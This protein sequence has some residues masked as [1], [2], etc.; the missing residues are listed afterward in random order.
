MSLSDTSAMILL[1]TGGAIHTSRNA[2]AYLKLVNLDAGRRL[3]NRCNKIW[4]HYDEVIKNRKK[5]IL[6]LSRQILKSRG[7]AQMVILGAGFDALS[8]E[9]L[10]H[11]KRLQ[12]Y[13]VDIAN[14]PLKERLVREAGVKESRIHCIDSDVRNTAG[15]I[16]AL[17]DR[18][19]RSAKPSLLVMEGFSYYLD[20]KELF[21]L[22]RTFQKNRQNRVVL[23]YLL[24]HKCI[25]K[26][27]ADIPA[28]VFDAIN[29]TYDV[30]LSRYDEGQ[31][32]K[33]FGPDGDT[34]HTFNLK[35]M[36]LARTGKN[37]Y[38]KS[39]ESGWIQVCE[40]AI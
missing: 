17:E 10:Y 20:R 6:D 5:C 8:V 14:M 12:I 7:I 25:S 27:R 36:E 3:F 4:N 22:I 24:P 39:R 38:F 1:W 31:I 34:V 18:G 30:P 11:T 37:T 9:M 21:D 33:L 29:N 35:E 15:L 26:D 19:W 23:D 28:K 16:D 32:K 2:K 40:I 13:D